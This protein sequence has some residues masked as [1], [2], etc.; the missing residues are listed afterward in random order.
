MTTDTAPTASTRP[1]TVQ[2]LHVPDCPNLA[3]L[4][5]RVRRALADLGLPV[6]VVPI[7][8]DYPSPTLLVNGTDVLPTPPSGAACRLELPTDTQIR[9]A[10]THA[11]TPGPPPSGGRHDP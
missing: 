6:T 7:V 10:L 4:L 8:G 11:L 3:L 5:T 2:V 9:D 1:V